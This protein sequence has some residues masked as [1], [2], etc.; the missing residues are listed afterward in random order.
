MLWI[1]SQDCSSPPLPS[2]S[3][4]VCCHQQKVL[5]SFRVAVAVLE[6]VVTSSLGLSIHPAI[7]LSHSYKH[8]I[9]GTPWGSV[10]LFCFVTVFLTKEWPE[11]DRPKAKSQPHWL[12][13]CRWGCWFDSCLGYEGLGFKRRLLLYENLLFHQNCGM[14]SRWKGFLNQPLDSRYL[15]ANL[16]PFSGGLTQQLLIFP[17]VPAAPSSSR[18]NTGVCAHSDRLLAT[19]CESTGA[20]TPSANLWLVW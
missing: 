6:D 10:F 13:R 12:C 20:A 4:F 9:S 17:A 8:N 18:N 14:R 2:C 15:K 1:L 19:P 11:F 16:F 3:C 7:C 5:N